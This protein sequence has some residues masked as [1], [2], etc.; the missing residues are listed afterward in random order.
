MW[1]MDVSANVL[2]LLKLTSNNHPCVGEQILGLHK[3]TGMARVEEVKNSISIDPH[4]P[5][6]CGRTCRRLVFSKHFIISAFHL[7]VH[8]QQVQK[9]VLPGVPRR[10]WAKV[11]FTRGTS[12]S[13]PESLA[14]LAGSLRVYKNDTW[15]SKMHFHCTFQCKNNWHPSREQKK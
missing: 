13:V 10:A 8:H 14:K 2:V 15:I 3:G 9:D 1:K 12:E 5:V 4:R 7:K 6:S 11:T